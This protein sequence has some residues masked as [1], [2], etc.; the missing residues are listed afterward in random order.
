MDAWKSCPHCGARLPE[1]ASFC[2]RCAQGINARREIASP[3]RIPRRALYG[4]LAVLAVLVLILAAWLHTRPR[5]YDNGTAEVI[6]TDGDGSYQLL[7]NYFSD[8][9][10]PMADYA[11]EVEEGTSSNKTSRLFINYVETG[12]NA[13]GFF[14]EKVAEV[15]VELLRGGGGPAPW[16]C[17]KPAVYNA[18]AKEPYPFAPDAACV[19]VL[20]YTDRSGDMELRWTLRMRNGDA[21][22]LYQ[23][24]ELGVVATCHFYPEDAP[25]DTLE[26]LRALVDRVNETVPAD[27]IVYLHLPAVTYEGSLALA[28]RSMNLVGSEGP[29]GRRT[30]FT[31]TLQAAA[32][33]GYI[34]H[35]DGLDFTG[36]GEGVGVSASA[37]IKFTSCRF[38]GWRTG[39]LCCGSAWVNAKNCVFEDNG[40]GLH[41]NSSGGSA[42]DYVYSGNLFQGNETAVLLEGVPGSQTLYFDGTRFSR[43]AVD[44]DNRCGHEVSIAEAIFE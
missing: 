11:E 1:E 16:Q 29:D 5:V 25:M 13:K 17:T 20:T 33:K 8:R 24:M 18:Y 40:V 22:R 4:S 34:C 27:M 26:D 2:P 39:V 36:P 37:G 14:L 35:F 3:R 43:N 42:D 7:L 28:G 44:I 21:I 12:A 10:Q 23:R 15:T 9:F 6:Y 31:G 32:Q 30:T 38:T 19:S 41:F